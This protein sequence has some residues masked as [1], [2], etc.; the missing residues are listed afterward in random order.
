MVLR[1]SSNGSS[2]LVGSWG[3]S[4]EKRRRLPSLRG[5]FLNE[6]FHPFENFVGAVLRLNNC[7]PLFFS[8][9]HFCTRSNT[10]TFSHFLRENDSSF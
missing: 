7:F 10:E 8:D 1:S 6:L 4:F 5:R 3:D 2:V 9:I